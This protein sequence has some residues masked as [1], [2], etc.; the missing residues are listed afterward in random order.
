MNIAVH[1]CIVNDLFSWDKELLDAAAFGSAI[2]NA[3]KIVMKDEIVDAK[4][5]QLLLTAKV[6]Q[7]EDR[8]FALVEKCG[9]GLSEESRRYIEFL[10]S[11]AAG[12]ESWSRLTARYNIVNG[13]RR[14]PEPENVS[15]REF[16]LA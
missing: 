8:H 11:M 10:V 1:V 14:K 3:V 5:A 16:S 2:V 6:Q 4:A 7:L 15:F 9:T 13:E 12:N